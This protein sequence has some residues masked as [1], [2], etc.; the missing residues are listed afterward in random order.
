MSKTLQG[1]VLANKDINMSAFT[2]KNER[3]KHFQMIEYE[4]NKWLFLPFI[5]GNLS[6]CVFHG[7]LGNL[8]INTNAIS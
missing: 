5:E 4:E 2:S 7:R 8:A 1:T 3:Y 6:F